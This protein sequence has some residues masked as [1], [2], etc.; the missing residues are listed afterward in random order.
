[1][2]IDSCVV[3]A[4]MVIVEGGIKFVEVWRANAE[5]NDV[6]ASV[7]KAF[8]KATFTVQRIDSGVFKV[9]KICDF[10]CEDKRRLNQ[11][12]N[13]VVWPKRDTSDEGE[14]NEE[15]KGGISRG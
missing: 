3:T 8:P 1:M 10:Y 6:R 4:W 2:T 11:S 9:S 15:W 5:I 7:R 12:G 13:I 14:K